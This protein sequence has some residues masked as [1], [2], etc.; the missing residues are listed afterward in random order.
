MINVTKA[1]LVPICILG[2]SSTIQAQ[3]PAP[4]TN[5]FV[6]VNTGSQGH[7]RSIQTSDSFPVYGETATL[8]AIQGLFEGGRIFDMS[9]GYRVWRNLG[10]AIG[11]ST[12]SDSRSGSVEASIPNP[13][14]V[15]RP[16]AV[17]S[18]ASGLSH[19]QRSVYFQAVW[20][21]PIHDKFEVSVGVGPSV[22]SVSQDVLAPFS[23]GFR[24]L[25]PTG[26]QDLK[27]G[28]PTSEDARAVTLMFQVDAMYFVAKNIG[29][30]IFV[31]RNGATVD[32]PSL[33]D[34]EVGGFQGG[35]G[36]RIR[37]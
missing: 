32:L 34:L 2:V 8:R 9:G 12:F 30:G 20:F 17:S 33:K 18:S 37:F 3:G 21:Q 19:S 24:T 25:I 5:V 29:G 27:L 6:S 35:F 36:A 22:F 26:T 11:F 31:R 28:G 13:L 15:N 16:K 4:S 1:L 7:S 23:S 14:F 10:V